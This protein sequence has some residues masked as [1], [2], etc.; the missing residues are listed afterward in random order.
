M[1][2][3]E[4]RHPAWLMFLSFLQT[5]VFLS[6]LNANIINVGEMG[7]AL[8][9]LFAN[10]FV[11]ALLMQSLWLQKHFY[12]RVDLFIFLLLVVWVAF[13]VVVDLGDVGYLKQVTIATTGGMLLFYF[14]GASLNVCYQSLMRVEKSSYLSKLIFFIYLLMLIWMLYNFSQRL[15][16]RLFYLAEV[17]GSYQRAGNFLSI[18]FIIVSYFYL[19]IS[20]KNVGAKNNACGKSLWIFLYTACVFLALVGAQLFGSNSATAVVSGVY[21]ITVVMTLLATQKEV[22]TNYFRGNLA[23]PFSKIVIKY[24]FA[25]VF[26]AIMLFTSFV[27]LIVVV[28][29]FDITQLRLFGFGS[30]T[31]T[32]IQSRVEILLENGSKQLGFSPV[33]GNMNVA[34]LTTGESGRYLHSFF[35][36]VMSNIGLVGLFIIIILFV[37]SFLRLYNESTP[38]GDRSILTYKRCMVSIYSVYIV[39]YLIVF[40]NLATSLSWAVL[41]F[42]LGF[43]SKPFGFKLND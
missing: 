31:N 36:Y 11:S 15:H 24:L 32:S 8:P 3:Q 12:V 27:F 4:L 10:I 43:V 29:E 21:L 34:Y 1:S 25:W 28:A 16:S 22:W 20:L 5:V 30:G 41:W 40:A 23:L 9:L 6:Y 2:S 17:D 13:R 33:F 38:K 26:V 14:V 19:A 35:P 42:S 7:T 39:G 18:S 37:V